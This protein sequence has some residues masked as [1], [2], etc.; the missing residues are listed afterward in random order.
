MAKGCRTTI[1]PLIVSSLSF[2]PVSACGTWTKDLFTPLTFS[3]DEVLTF[4][5]VKSSIYN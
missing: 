5:L 4:R 1:I 3:S 2:L